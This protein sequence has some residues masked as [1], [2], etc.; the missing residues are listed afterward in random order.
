MLDHIISKI[1]TD[2]FCEVCG[3]IKHY[4][5]NKDGR[6]EVVECKTCGGK[7]YLSDSS[8]AS[9][10]LVQNLQSIPL[11]IRQ[12]MEIQNI[13]AVDPT[14]INK[15]V[16]VLVKRLYVYNVPINSY[17]FKFAYNRL[18]APGPREIHIYF[19]GN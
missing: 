12:T 19:D 11:G 7:G 16:G 5:L 15:L 8:N 13:V 1:V 6:S 3:G 10:L 17:A 9:A 4:R 18:A 2:R 14:T